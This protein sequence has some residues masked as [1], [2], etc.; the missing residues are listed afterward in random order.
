MNEL[1]YVENF[2]YDRINEAIEELRE[3]WFVENQMD[4]DADTSLEAWMSSDT[5]RQ[6]FEVLR[7]FG[8]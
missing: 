7:K 6:A 2:L 4:P 1:D 5:Y 8:G 3:D